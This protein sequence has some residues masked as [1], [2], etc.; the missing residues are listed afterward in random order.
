MKVSSPNRHWADMCAPCKI[1]AVASRRRSS[2]YSIARPSM[3]I[4]FRLGASLMNQI[5]LA[6]S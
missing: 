3:V 5:L 2:R 4:T 6:P 1:S